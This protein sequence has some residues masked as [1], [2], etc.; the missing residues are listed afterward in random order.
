MKI[1]EELYLSRRSLLVGAGLLLL[2]AGA[3]GLRGRIVD[4]ADFIV[5]IVRRKVDYVIIPEPD[6]RRFAEDYAKEPNWRI[7]RLLRSR[8]LNLFYSSPGLFRSLVLAA[9]QEKIEMLERI[10]VTDFLV[11]T[12]YFSGETQ[13]GK[14]LRYQGM[15]KGACNNPFAVFT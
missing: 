12:D 10:V 9:Y 7:T 15:Q 6:L 3:F 5:M 14:A 8:Q 1:T 4:K 13:P 11:A 2:G